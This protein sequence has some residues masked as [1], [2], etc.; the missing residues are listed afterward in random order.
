MAD[1]EGSQATASMFDDIAT[2]WEELAAHVAEA[3]Q[4]AMDEISLMWTN[5]TLG[6]FNFSMDGLKEA[7]SV[8]K[9][10]A[11]QEATAFYLAVE[12]SE[13]FIQAILGMHAVL[14]ALF[15]GACIFGSSQNFKVVLFF[16]VAA[17]CGAGSFVNDYGAANWE[18]IAKTNYF[19]KNG[20]FMSI[21]WC[22]PLL[23]LLFFVLILILSDLCKAMVSA[24]TVQI[25]RRLQKER[26]EAQ[27]KNN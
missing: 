9:D 1:A 13:P 14:W 5:S 26:A 19:D 10:Q 21:V 24:K 2:H 25:K 7:S 22:V 27:K 18:T 11:V 12:W 3:N 4:E 20:V 17:L 6:Q 16:T 15:F 8:A 23:L